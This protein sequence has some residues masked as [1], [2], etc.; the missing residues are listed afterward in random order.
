MVNKKSHHIDIANLK[1]DEGIKIPLDFEFADVIGLSN[2]VRMKLNK[3]RPT[4]LASA[5]A[6]RARL[7]YEELL[8]V[9][10]LQR[11]A[12][13]LAAAGPLGHHTHWTSPTHARPGV[14]TDPAARVHR[15]GEWFREQGLA[16]TIFCGGGW[17]T[18][19]AVAAACAS[20]GYVD[21]TPRA[22]RP[23]YL[24]PGASWACL[25][26]PA[27]LETAA[28]ELMAVPTTHSIGDITRAVTR[29]RGLPDPVVHV[30]FHDTDLLHAGRRAALVAALHLLGRRRTAS[31]IDSA[32][33]LVGAAAPLIPFAAVA[34]GEA[35]GPPE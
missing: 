11:R 3:H 6:G 28:G 35:S 12:R 9:H 30:Y 15:E 13:Q 18:D 32:A 23:S 26:A 4:T 17:Y 33:A 31:D 16:P 14:G 22:R 34:G 8:F 20:L 24:Q 2:E 27:R 21:C 29:P 7:A 5:L 10:L 19:A 1:R 25:A